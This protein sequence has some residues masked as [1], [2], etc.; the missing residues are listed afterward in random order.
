MIEL[1][2]E[3]HLALERSSSNAVRAVDP[4]TRAEYVLLRAD[5]YDRIKSILG[6]SETWPDDAY[7]GAIEVFARDGWDD[8]RMEVYDNLDPRRPK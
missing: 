1:T 8:P 2:P 7:R 3:Q 6:D 4:A 5:V